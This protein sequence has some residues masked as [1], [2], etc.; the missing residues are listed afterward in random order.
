MLNVQASIATVMP[1]IQ[2]IPTPK[3]RLNSNLLSLL[4][5]IVLCVMVFTLADSLA[6]VCQSEAA[7][8]NR[9]QKAHVASGARLAAA[10]AA[11]VVAI[12]TGNLIAVGVATLVILALLASHDSTGANLAAANQ[13]YWD[14]IHREGGG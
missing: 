7:A 11:L 1:P 10:E 3:F 6:Q 9:A 4:S 14:C 12:A 13:A 5:L 8:L 2:A